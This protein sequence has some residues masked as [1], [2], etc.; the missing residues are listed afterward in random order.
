ME[1]SSFRYGIIAVDRTFNILHYCGYE[2]PPMKEDFDHLRWELSTDEELG[3]TGRIGE[4]E[5]VEAPKDV[6]AYYQR[7]IVSPD[8]E[9]LPQET[10]TGVVSE[11]FKELVLKTR[12]V[13]QPS[14]VRIPPTPY[15]K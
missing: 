11:R 2:R 9:W 5:L 1:L 7:I 6:V 8:T 3:L 14:W 12:M 15:S 10:E 4:F 13:S